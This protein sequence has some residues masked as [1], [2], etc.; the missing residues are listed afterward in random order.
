VKEAETV[1]TLDLRM[2][3]VFDNV[4]VNDGDEG[5]EGGEGGWPNSGPEEGDEGDEG[6]ELGEVTEDRLG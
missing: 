3:Y 6:F 2:F 1:A 4:F 5:G